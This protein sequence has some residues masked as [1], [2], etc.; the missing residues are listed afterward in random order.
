MKYSIF[1]N[2]FIYK[3]TNA[4][5]SA[6]ESQL[7]IV[8]EWKY[9][10]FVY[11]TFVDRQKAIQNGDFIPKNNVPLGIDYFPNRLFITTPRWKNGVPATLSTISYL[12]K[13]IS[14]AL[15]PYPKWEDHG[16]PENPDCSKL[17][18]V[19]RT[20]IDK[21][22]R[23]WL[24]D[25]GIVNATINLKQ[26]CSPKIVVYDLST[27][28]LLVRYDFPKSQVKEDS[29]HSNI[30]VDIGKNCE[31][32]HA[33]VSDV[34]R[35]G[36]VVYS[37]SKNRSWRITNY[38]FFPNPVASDFTIDGLN[39][40]WLDG[41]FGMSIAPNQS[42]KDKALYFHPMASFKEFMVSMNLLINEPLWQSN[43]QENAK[44]FFSIG[45]R[46]F[47]GQ[48]ST[49]GIS[50]TGVMFFTQVHQNNIGCW[51]TARPY[52]RANLKKLD[53]DNGLIQF[54]NDLKVDNEVNQNVWI[55]SNRLPV[56]L[57][58]Q[59]DF[60]E[61]NFRILKA[62]INKIINNTVCDPMNTYNNGSKSAVVSIEE[63]QCY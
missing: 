49:S 37:L 50:K 40:Q 14:P 8:N 35:F 33:I 27:D 41:I 23:L 53:Q 15:K 51:N 47:N 43:S 29:L 46:G 16:N 36:L 9:L 39:F 4:Q 58:S 3:Y 24:I 57:Y 61:I 28:Q 30:V 25:S 34:W 2:L 21:C 56:F 26:I 11:P 38:N 17:I 13:E 10:D 59:L 42:R 18:S 19:Y 5:S 1:Q 32:A 22:H 60:G 20:A 52:I 12:S 63:G 45:D 48:S 7:E 44:Y 62:D 55:M 54:P 6:S 31:D